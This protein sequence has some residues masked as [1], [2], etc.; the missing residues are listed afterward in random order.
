MLKC[1]DI[2]EHTS[3]YLDPALPW[4]KKVACYLHLA[5]CHHCRR[6]VRQF[7]LT[8]LLARRLPRLQASEEDVTKIMNHLR[9]NDYHKH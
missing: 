2:A 7:R 1:K 4:R 8:V 5:I 6:F 3:H 9:R